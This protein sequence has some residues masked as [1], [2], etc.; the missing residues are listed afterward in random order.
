MG[1]YEIV[2]PD[3][4]KYKVEAPDFDKANADLKEHMQGLANKKA[5]EEAEAAPA[6]A[7]PFM[8][9]DDV[10]RVGL[11]AATFGLADKGIG[12]FTGKDEAMETEARR[13]RM[14]GA[15]LPAAVVGAAVGPS[16]VPSVMRYMGGGPIARGL[17]GTTAAGIEGGVAGGIGAAMHDE[18]IAPGVAMGSAGQAVGQTVGPIVNKA[19]KSILRIDDSVPQGIKSKITVLPTK[20]ATKSDK[21][22]V[23][24]EEA[25]LYAKGS[26]N[27][28]A[29]QERLKENYKK[30]YQKEGKT[31]TKEQRALM[32]DIFDED[33]ATRY[34]RKLGDI[35]SN[36]L[37]A[38][39][40]GFTTGTLGGGGVVGGLA[41]TGGLLGA[42][43]ALRG[44]SSNATEEAV[45]DLRRAMF[46]K[47]KYQGILSV[48]DAA[49][50]SRAA[51]QLGFEY[52]DEE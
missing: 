7:K 14:G 51:R 23:A 19:A 10:A 11:D 43:S 46:N 27:P 26:D 41:T 18:P 35:L 29:R 40:V 3:G 6:W 15:A 33:P 24:D 17:V 50:A 30:L 1:T 42:G 2:A 44:V 34:S 48:E 13:Q 39:G 45:R 5:V 36:K 12:Y 8:A 49:R 47:K 16:A 25:A 31:Y 52:Y 28:L 20:G 21:V 32:G 9:A 38:S 37:M 4:A 22:T